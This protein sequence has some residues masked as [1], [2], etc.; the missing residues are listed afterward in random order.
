ME[1]ICLDKTIR[2]TRDVMN[3][4]A[5]IPKGVNVYYELGGMKSFRMDNSQVRIPIEHIGLGILALEQARSQFAVKV[6]NQDRSSYERFELVN[7]DQGYYIADFLQTVDPSALNWYK[8]SNNQPL[9]MQY[10]N[11]SVM[12]QDLTKM[13]ECK[14]LN[15]EGEDIREITVREAYRSALSEYAQ[16]FYDIA[17]A[18]FCDAVKEGIVNF[19]N[20]DKSV[21]EDGIQQIIPQAIQRLPQ[22][23]AE[24]PEA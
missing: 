19:V 21:F 10:I 20:E 15:E 7:H 16:T 11:S 4:D 3:E 6:V 24:A 17:E 13:K 9:Q 23:P 14:A 5:E 2:L 22:E 12:R 1:R 18:P 8:D